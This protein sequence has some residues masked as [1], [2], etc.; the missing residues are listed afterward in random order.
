MR[1]RKTNRTQLQAL[2]TCHNVVGRQWQTLLLDVSDGGCKIIDPANQMRVGEAVNLYF[3]DS[4]PHMAK[5][6]WRRGDEVGLEFR[7]PL[8]D[9]LLESLSNND[10][11]RTGADVPDGAPRVAMLRFV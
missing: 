7:E 5:Y 9:P 1:T 4:G 3:A 11:S 2:A 8:S 10:W 6:T